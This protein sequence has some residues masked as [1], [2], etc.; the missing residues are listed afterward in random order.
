MTPLSNAT[1]HTPQISHWPYCSMAEC[2]RPV[3]SHHL[4][5]AL[6]I[7]RKILK[8]PYNKNTRRLFYKFL[9]LDERTTSYFDA[10]CDGYLL[11]IEAA[12]KIDMLLGPHA[13]AL[14]KAYTA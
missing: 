8:H 13:Y 4:A 12:R 10:R 14:L 6:H 7:Y 11:P 9:G 3:Q 2:R 5:D 1:G